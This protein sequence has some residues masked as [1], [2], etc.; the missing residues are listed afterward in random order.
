MSAPYRVSFSGKL[1]RLSSLIDRLRVQVV[2]AMTGGN[3][4]DNANLKVYR[5]GGGELRLVFSPISDDGAGDFPQ[6]RPVP[7]EAV[8]VA[9]HIRISG[10][11]KHLVNA[12]PDCLSVS[13]SEEPY[14]TA[15]VMPLIEEVTTPRCGGQAAFQRL[16]EV[17]VIR[18][19]RHALEQG[20]ADTGLLSGLAHP[21][22]AVA[23][24]AIHEAPGEAWT[25]EKLASTAG[26]SRTQFA[27]TFK[28]LVGETPMGYLSN[29]RL[30]IARAELETGRQVKI[31]A[32]LCGFASPAAFSRAY[33]RRFG[34]SPKKRGNEAA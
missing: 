2:N 18:L 32:S 24:V 27:V 30:D 16:C 17:V 23:L 13:L 22:I 10:I 33:S 8:L 5:N 7:D 26:M 29:W 19:L 6:M 34:H 20:Q 21:R 25:L 31:V 3:D 14:L 4:T 15:V 1:D 28:D 11:G 12:L 9:A